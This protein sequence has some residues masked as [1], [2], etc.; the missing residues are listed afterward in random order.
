MPLFPLH[1]FLAR[2]VT[3]VTSRIPLSAMFGV[4]QVAI[5]FR[6]QAA[7]DYRLGQ[8]LEQPILGQDILLIGVLFQ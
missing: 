1:G 3:R 7:L 5:Q 4:A 8:L 6:F 2:A